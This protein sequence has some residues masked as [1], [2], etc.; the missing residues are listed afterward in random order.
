MAERDAQRSAISGVERATATEALRLYF[1]LLA[2]RETRAV[3]EKLLA[4]SQRVWQAAEAA[5][6]RGAGAGVEAD[7]AQAAHLSIVRR[8]LD[9]ARDEHVARAS[10]ANLLG[11]DDLERLEVEGS[12]E[13][14]SRAAQVRG[15]L[16]PPDSPE[17]LALSAEQR[18]AMARASAFRRSRVPNPTLSVFVQRDGFDE[19][20]V[21]LGLA[22]P[23]TLPEPLGRTSAG[24]IAENEA[25]AERAA[26]LA[27]SGRRMLRVD[28]ARALASYTAAERAVR[29][30]SDE[31]VSRAEQTTQSLA[32]EAEAGRVAVR[33]AMMLQ[34]PLLELLLGAIESRKALCLASVELLRASGLPLDGGAP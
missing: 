27:E 11:R 33:D 18:A 6:E 17:I 29:A 13:P 19:Q 5:S 10:L 9:A 4:A 24:E 34:T 12:L 23:L 8:E 32:L 16:A 31:R 3:L 26:I 22:F 1:E 7:V 14:L 2:A 15:R 28:L 30:F 20:V 21:G 25:L